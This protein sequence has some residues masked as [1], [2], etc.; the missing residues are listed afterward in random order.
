MPDDITQSARYKR[1][2]RHSDGD[3]GMAPAHTVC[4]RPP[5]V[6]RR[7]LNHPHR[8]HRTLGKTRY[9]PALRFV[10]TKVFFT[11]SCLRRLDSAQCHFFASTAD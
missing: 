6:Y 11:I 1:N 2:S 8:T 9:Y 7:I 5:S 10:S 4:V 3:L